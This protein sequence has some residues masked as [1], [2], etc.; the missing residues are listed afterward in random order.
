M[1]CVHDSN[2]ISEARAL[3][4]GCAVHPAIRKIWGWLVPF[5]TSAYW[6]TSMV[7][8]KLLLI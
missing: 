5:V 8:E 7:V 1:I 4:P 3:D 2:T 6:L